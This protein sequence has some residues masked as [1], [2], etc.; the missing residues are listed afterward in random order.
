[1]N[2]EPDL[3]DFVP[4]ALMVFMIKEPSTLIFMTPYRRT[5][6]REHVTDDDLG[7]WHVS[8]TDGAA[9]AHNGPKLDVS[10][11]VLI[12]AAVE[13]EYDDTSTPEHCV[14]T[15]LSPRIDLL[16]LTNKGLTWLVGMPK[17]WFDNAIERVVKH[18]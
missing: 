17:L 16:L 9:A 2:C 7:R 10:K 3:S 15:A 14:P 4:G 18:V 12:L 13:T 5:L 1:M 8:Y 6:H 11:P